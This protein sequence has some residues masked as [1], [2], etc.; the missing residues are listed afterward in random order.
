MWKGI[1]HFFSMQCACCAQ[2][3]NILYAYAKYPTDKRH[4]P[5]YAVCKHSRL[6]DTVSHN[7]ICPTGIYISIVKLTVLFVLFICFSCSV[8][9]FHDSVNIFYVTTKTFYFRNMCKINNVHFS[10]TICIIFLQLP[11]ILYNIKIL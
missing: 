2:Y 11:K 4:F 10:K 1:L 5:K 7:P 3:V 8:F 9:F 6:Q